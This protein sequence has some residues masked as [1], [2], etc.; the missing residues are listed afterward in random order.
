V[1]AK[2]KF[3]LLAHNVFKDDDSRSNASIIVSN[4]QLLM[5]NDRYLY[6]IGKQQ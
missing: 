1:A 4:G 3:E 6:C 2:S 5:R